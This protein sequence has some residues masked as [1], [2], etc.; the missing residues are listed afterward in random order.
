MRLIAGVVIGIVTAS[1]VLY[2]CG[3][4][5]DDTPG[6]VPVVAAPGGETAVAPDNSEPVEQMVERWKKL[7]ESATRDNPPLD[8]ATKL[9]NEI[10]VR[11][12]RALL[13]LLDLV[14]DEESAPHVKV[15]ATLSL[16]PVMGPYVS[17]RLI[18]M[19]KPGKDGTTRACATSLLRQIPTEDVTAAL[20]QLKNDS[21]PRV[22]LYAQLGL[23]TRSVEERNNLYEMWK[24]G[25]LSVQEKG[26][27]IDVLAGSPAVKDIPL[28]QE[29]AA[30]KEFHEQ[31]RVL[32]VEALGKVGAEEQI[33]VLKN[34]AKDDP[35]NKVQIAAKAALDGL[36]AR[37]SGKN[38]VTV[39]VQ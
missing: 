24:K 2:G 32:A 13:S 36:N 19:T 4:G 38:Q 9:A 26:T 5:K 35:S 21:E 11:D 29:T 6:G 31:A 27:V 25:E 22:K 8:E 37:L 3:G 39:P 23:A 7:A 20:K 12:P 16:A 14:E 18:E 15:L 34:Y 30:D 10:A 28:F 33:D 17:D 1:L